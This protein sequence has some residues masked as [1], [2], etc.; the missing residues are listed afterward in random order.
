MDKRRIRIIFINT[1]SIRKYPYS[2]SLMYGSVNKIIKSFK[3][4]KI[5]R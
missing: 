2:L 1:F 4:T 3:L 5:Y